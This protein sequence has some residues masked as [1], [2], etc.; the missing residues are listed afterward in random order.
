MKSEVI[1]IQRAVVWMATLTLCAFLFIAPLAAS[2]A[3]RIETG[4]LDRQI[5]LDSVTYRY[6]VYVPIDYV[7]GKPCPVIL[8]LH[9]LAEAGE[10]G[11]LQTQVGLGPAIRQTRERF[12]HRRLPSGSS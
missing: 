11:L 9:G 3:P 10:D 6:Q 1:M 12:I 4:F 8:F 7:R 2:A 5:T